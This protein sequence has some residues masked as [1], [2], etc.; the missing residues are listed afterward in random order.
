MRAL[1]TVSAALMPLGCDVRKWPGLTGEQTYIA[2]T[3]LDI[4]GAVYANNRPTRRV[5]EVQVDLYT[6]DAPEALT[7]LIMVTLEAARCPVA[8]VGPEQF[9]PD[10]AYHHIPIVCQVAHEAKTT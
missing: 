7:D 4:S 5:A 2:L 6:K 10:T 3:L 8:R 1:E 9:E